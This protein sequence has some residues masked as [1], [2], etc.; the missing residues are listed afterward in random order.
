MQFDPYSEWLGLPAGR[1]PPTY[2]ELLGLAAF[3]SNP[4][5]TK[6]PP[7]S[8]MPLSTAIKAASA[9]PKPWPCLPKSPPREPA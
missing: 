3:E 7:S 6:L 5:Q 4:Q 9:K 1:R 2:Y 8:G